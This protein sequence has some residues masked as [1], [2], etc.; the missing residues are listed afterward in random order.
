MRGWERRG[1]G[2]IRAEKSLGRDGYQLWV[3]LN[4]LVQAL[5]VLGVKYGREDYKGIVDVL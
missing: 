3:V 4:Q 2:F 1:E 5:G